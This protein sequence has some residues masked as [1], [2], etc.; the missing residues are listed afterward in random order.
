MTTTFRIEED[1]EPMAT[2]PIN[3][4]SDESENSTPNTN[5]GPPA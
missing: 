2:E 3:L 5:S 4:S 1:E